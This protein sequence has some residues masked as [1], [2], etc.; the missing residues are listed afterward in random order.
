VCFVCVCVC[1]NIQFCCVHML[2]YISDCPTV[3][4]LGTGVAVCNHVFNRRCFNIYGSQLRLFLLCGYQCHYRATQ[5]GY[6]YHYRTTQFGHQC[7]YRATQCGHQCHYRATQ[8]G[9]QYHYRATQCLYHQ[10]NAVPMN[11][12]VDCSN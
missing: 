12:N 11:T 10:K 2:A 1:N 8:C 5:C 3:E 6:Q 4:S 9:H 7:H